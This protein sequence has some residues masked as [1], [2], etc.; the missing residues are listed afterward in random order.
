[1]LRNASFHFEQAV[2]FHVHFLEVAVP[3]W[4]VQDICHRP[5]EPPLHVNH[6]FVKEVGDADK[7]ELIQ[8]VRHK[9][10]ELSR[11]VDVWKARN[12][13]Q[14]KSLINSCERAQAC[15]INK[16]NSAHLL[17]PSV[18]GWC[19]LSSWVNGFGYHACDLIT[20]HNCSMLVTNL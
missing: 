5:V 15:A 13:G 19:V 7:V 9:R 17:R 3:D 1:M 18:Q 2:S 16:D 8:H 20:S 11:R 14:P 10:A 4:L 12:Q 6:A